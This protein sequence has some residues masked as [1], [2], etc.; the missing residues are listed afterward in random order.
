MR[1]KAHPQ[2]DPNLRKIP[3]RRIAWHPFKF[4]VIPGLGIPVAVA[5]FSDS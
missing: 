3:H 5:L 4:V 2:L 1:L